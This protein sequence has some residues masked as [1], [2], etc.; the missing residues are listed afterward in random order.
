MDLSPLNDNV[1]PDRHPLPLIE[2]IVV[3]IRGQCVFSKIDLQKG[4]FHNELDEERKP[5]MA[6]ITPL[7]LMAYN[8][9][10]M[11][12]RDATSV[13]QLVLFSNLNFSFRNR[14]RNQSLS[15]YVFEIEIEIEVYQNLF[16]KSKSIRICFRN[17]NRN[18][19]S[20]EFVFEIEIVVLLLT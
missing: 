18:R 9:L 14:N 4:Y 3:Q 11:G 1:V 7:G 5:L 2:D 15:E 12:H 10:L 20:S 6:T 17:R 8:R 19:S 13:F 16:S